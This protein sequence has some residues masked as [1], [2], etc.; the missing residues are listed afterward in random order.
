MCKYYSPFLG[1]KYA[2]V[3][4]HFIFI[5]GSLSFARNVR[6][7]FRV[8]PLL[9]TPLHRWFWVLKMYTK[10]Y[11]LPPYG[12]ML[13]LSSVFSFKWA[14]MFSWNISK[15]LFILG[16]TESCLKH[17]GNGMCLR[18]KIGVKENVWTRPPVFQSSSC[19][20]EVC[21]ICWASLGCQINTFSTENENGWRSS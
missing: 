20:F 5:I 16:F 19:C 2:R 14:K 7:K 6:Y 8:N 15:W 4:L 12:N 17:H 21:S 18:L 11:Q 13:D 9:W 10:V 3:V 1:A